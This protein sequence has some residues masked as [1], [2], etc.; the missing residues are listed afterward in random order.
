MHNMQTHAHTNSRTHKH[1]H[2]RMYKALQAPS[3]LNP[4]EVRYDDLTYTRTLGIC[5]RKM[6]TYTRTLGICVRKMPTYTRTPGI[7]VRK[8]PTYTRTYCIRVTTLRNTFLYVK[9]YTAM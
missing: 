7:C 1:T 2:C 6:P 8:M 4:S 3:I 9:C 5:V